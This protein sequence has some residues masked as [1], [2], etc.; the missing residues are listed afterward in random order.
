MKP[1]LR[2]PGRLLPAGTPL[3]WPPAGLLGGMWRRWAPSGSGPC[4][5]GRRRG[6]GYLS[7]NVSI[8]DG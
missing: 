1:E 8:F 3:G 6:N 7:G 4:A 2:Q 5:G